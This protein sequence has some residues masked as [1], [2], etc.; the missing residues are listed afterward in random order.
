MTAPSP[1]PPARW[2]SAQ[3]IQQVIDNLCRPSPNHRT[4]SLPTSNTGAGRVPARPASGTRGSEPP[5]AERPG[6]RLPDPGRPTPLSVAPAVARRPCSTSSPRFLD[7]TEGNRARQRGGGRSAV[8]RPAGGAGIG[9][10]AAE[11]PS[12]SPARWASKPPLR[13]ARKPRRCSLWQALETAQARQFRRGPAPDSST[14]ASRRGGANLVR[15]PAPATVHCSGA[16]ASA[17]ACTS[18]TTVSRPWTRPPTPA[19]RAALFAETADATVVIVAQRA[20]HDPRRRSR[21]SSWT[22][23]TYRGDRGTHPELMVGC[24]ALPGNHRVTTRLG[25]GRVRRA[26]GRRRAAAPAGNAP[27]SPA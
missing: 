1:T 14:P 25:S 9:P 13:P 26:D 21:S 17:R 18:S 11:R 7:A 22:G 20:R 15:G 10:G 23:G 16:R 8:E 5:R 12:C 24:Q 2:T 27:F 6:V 19:L 4:R 3:R